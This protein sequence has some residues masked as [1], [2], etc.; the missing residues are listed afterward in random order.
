MSWIS[1]Q[2][3][4]VGNRAQRVISVAMIH[5][6]NGKSVG[7]RTPWFLFI[8]PPANA[9]TQA[10]ISR[11]HLR[12]KNANFCSTNDR[13]RGFLKRPHHGE[14]GWIERE[15]KGTW[16]SQAKNYINIPLLASMVL[17]LWIEWLLFATRILFYTG[18]FWKY[19]PFWRDENKCVNVG[20]QK[21]IFD[22]NL[23]IKL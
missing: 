11:A 23:F 7:T 15:G 17:L 16:R 5:L 12:R 22:W 20:I 14:D 13:K 10:S 19:F 6:R 9:Y 2:D 8:I 3:P 21:C 18:Y 4:S 1:W